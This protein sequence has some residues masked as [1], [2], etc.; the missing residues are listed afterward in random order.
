M[1]VEKLCKL[2][3]CNTTTTDE[4]SGNITTLM[5]YIFQNLH[6][7]THLKLVDICD[8]TCEV[9]STPVDVL[10]NNG[11]TWVHKEKSTFVYTIHYNVAHIPLFVSVVAGVDSKLYV[12]D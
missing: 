10:T 1:R 12:D 4:L 3:I 8:I 5:S 11:G 2:I 7:A 9:D 6:E